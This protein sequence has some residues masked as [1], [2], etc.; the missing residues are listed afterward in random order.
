MS[1]GKELFSL[2]MLAIIF[3][4]VMFYGVADY[5]SAT[6]DLNCG[7]TYPSNATALNDTATELSQI[8]IRGCQADQQ[9]LLFAIIGGVDLLIFGVI[10]FIVLPLP[11]VK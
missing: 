4:I 8:S 2:G 3:N 9:F 5:V 10:L 1:H 6:G 7:I 11:F